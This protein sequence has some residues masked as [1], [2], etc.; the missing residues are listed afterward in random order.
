MNRNAK[1]FPKVRQFRRLGGNLGNLTPL[2][3]V[4]VKVHRW[5]SGWGEN[6]FLELQTAI[7]DFPFQRVGGSFNPSL[8][9]EF[10]RFL[11][12][13]SC[14]LRYVLD[15]DGVRLTQLSVY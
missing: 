4:V 12:V 9:P 1:L 2:E 5:R 8:S 11:Q 7:E 15:I 13:S 10:G 6:E 14:N 3:A